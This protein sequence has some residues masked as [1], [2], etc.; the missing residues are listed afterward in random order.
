VALLFESGGV[1]QMDRVVVVY[2]DPETELSRL[3]T[4]DG[5]PEAECRARIA[6]QM[7]VADKAKR[8]DYVIDNSGPRAETERQVRTVYAAL[9]GD[10]KSRLT[11]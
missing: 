2:T 6:S 10:L 4:R 8:A 9:L 7:S 5:R 3:V 1:S 11:A